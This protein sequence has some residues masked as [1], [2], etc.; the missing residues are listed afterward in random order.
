MYSILVDRVTALHWSVFQA[1]LMAQAMGRRLVEE[2]PSLEERLDQL[3]DVMGVA[4]RADRKYS[5]DE[6][7]LR[8]ALGLR[9]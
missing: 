4:F 8:R 7:A 9:G 3:A 6:L 5:P 2:P 1:T